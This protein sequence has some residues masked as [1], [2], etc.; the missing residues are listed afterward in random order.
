MQ[1]IFSA[2]RDADIYR[3]VDDLLVEHLDTVSAD[4]ARKAV[5]SWLDNFGEES[6]L[7]KLAAARAENAALRR[8][9]DEARSAIKSCLE[10]IP[11][12]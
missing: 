3:V 11:S 5:K 6:T 10:D 1:K 9:L 12:H 7:S 8:T 2:T 4:I